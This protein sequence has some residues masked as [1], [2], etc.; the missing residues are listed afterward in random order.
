MLN[1]FGNVIVKV[2]LKVIWD[3]TVSQ[4]YIIKDLSTDLSFWYNTLSQWDTYVC[5]VFQNDKVMHQTQ[6]SMHI[7]VK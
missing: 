4:L 5:K 6:P 7:Y 2:C 1:M 3:Q